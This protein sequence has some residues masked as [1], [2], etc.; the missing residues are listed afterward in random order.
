MDVL[1]RQ[2][3]QNLKVDKVRAADGT[4]AAKTLKEL[5]VEAK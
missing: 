1:H 5:G 2:G 3:R 4:N